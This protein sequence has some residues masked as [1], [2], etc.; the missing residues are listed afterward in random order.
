[1]TRIATTRCRQ[2]GLEYNIHLSL[3]KFINKRGR[4]GREEGCRFVSKKWRD[5]IVPR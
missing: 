3:V 4:S 2:Q 1:M 5:T